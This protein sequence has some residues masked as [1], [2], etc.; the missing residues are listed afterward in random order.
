MAVSGI[1]VQAHVPVV[2]FPSQNALC[3]C[4]S[5]THRY[6]KS[7]PPG[8]NG[9]LVPRKWAVPPW[10]VHSQARPAGSWGDLAALCPLAAPLPPELRLGNHSVGIQG[11][12]PADL[13]VTFSSEPPW[14]RSIYVF[15]PTVTHIH[16]GF[17]QPS[18]GPLLACRCLTPSVQAQLGGSAVVGQSKWGEQGAV[19]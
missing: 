1:S 17:L 19:L 8:A 15:F 6:R 10:P 9:L 13:G 12:A 2:V 5:D 7:P 16:F 14:S 4:A 11:R 18:S 3:L